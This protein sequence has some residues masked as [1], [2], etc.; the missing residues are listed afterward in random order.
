LETATFDNADTMG[1]QMQI[2]IKAQTI[3]VT[4]GDG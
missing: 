3:V 2:L 4:I 1:F